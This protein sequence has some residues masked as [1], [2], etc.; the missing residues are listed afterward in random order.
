M[1]LKKRIELDNGI[2][3][4]YHRIVSVTNVVNKNTV[5]EVQSYTS[6]DKRLEEMAWYKSPDKANVSPMNVFI[7]SRRYVIDSPNLNLDVSE[8]YDH[9]KTLTQF[10]G[11]LDI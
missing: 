8:A 11:A 2:V 3:L 1:A 9:L 6:Q 10:E 5:I 4:E 7:D